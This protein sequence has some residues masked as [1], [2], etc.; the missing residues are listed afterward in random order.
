VSRILYRLTDQEPKGRWLVAIRAVETLDFVTATVSDVPWH[1]LRKISES[2]L[3]HC[4]NVAAVYYDITPKPP[5]S[6]EFE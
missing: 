4:K 6:I 5:A 2:I 1:I 3:D